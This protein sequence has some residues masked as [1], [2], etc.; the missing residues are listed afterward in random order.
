M[1]LTNACTIPPGVGFW[2]EYLHR[3]V[4]LLAQKRLCRYGTEVHQGR[5]QGDCAAGPMCWSGCCRTLG[6]APMIRDESRKRCRRP[7]RPGNPRSHHRI[8]TGSHRVRPTAHH[9]RS[10]RHLDA[11]TRS[12][13][14]DS[15]SA[16][17]ARRH[18][19]NWLTLGSF[20]QSRSVGAR[21]L[22]RPNLIR[23]SSEPLVGGDVGHVPYF[24]TISG[25]HAV[26]D[27][28]QLTLE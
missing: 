8:H 2:S 22:L 3:T 10:N 1:L 26:Q 9:R 21:S 17:S 23:T 19:T 24:E 4:D 16:A 18:S 7:A 20:R 11:S 14:L 13:K 25:P 12:P 5:A 28:E 6:N 15:N 27:S